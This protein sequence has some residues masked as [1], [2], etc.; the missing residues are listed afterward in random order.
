MRQFCY[1]I[2]S[3]LTLMFVGLKLADKIDW[4][5]WWVFSPIWITVI[6]AVLVSLSVTLLVAFEYK[7]SKQFR[8]AF[9]FRRKISQRKNMTFAERI[10]EMKKQKEEIEENAR[11]R[12][13]CQAKKED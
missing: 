4:S 8:E 9:D 2:L 12:D 7:H 3:A 10:A 11:R 5:W 1:Y 6:I 13:K